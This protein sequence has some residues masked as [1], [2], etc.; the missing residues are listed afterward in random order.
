MTVMHLASPKCDVSEIARR[1]GRAWGV[2]AGASLVQYVEWSNRTGLLRALASREGRS[3]S[4]VCQE[5]VLNEGGAEALIGVLVSMG[6][7][8]SAPSGDCH[9]LTELSREYLAPDSP[10]YIG[11]G[12]FWDCTDDVPSAY[13]AELGQTKATANWS[14]EAR[15][16][17]QHS[18][19]FA[20]CVTAARIG[21]FDEAARI[22]DVGGGSGTFAIPI[23][24]D[25]PQASVFLLEHPTVAPF[26]ARYLQRYGVTDRVTVVPM[27]VFKV[28]WGLEA[29]DVAFLGNLL[30]SQNDDNA[31]VILDRCWR[32]LTESGALWVH[33]VLFDERP[34]RPQIAALWNANMIA[35]GDGGEQR[36]YGEIVR[37][38]RQVGFADFQR[39]PTSGGFSLVGGRKLASRRPPVGRK[40][41]RP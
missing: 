30:H 19:N 38:M 39:I 31:L 18:R 10:Y 4:Q 40:P 8:E 26:V 25:N 9:V 1:V 32:H 41:F 11:E 23:V 6:F 27:D 20:P 24:L 29:S 17:I 13:L 35:H 14:A 34:G 36:T 3:I 16:G 37:L 2:S 5:T 7:V 22:V 12:L 28:D 21:V 15:L 33:E